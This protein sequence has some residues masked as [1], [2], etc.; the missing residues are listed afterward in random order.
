M[1]C[2]AGNVDSNQ[3]CALVSSPW[4]MVHISSQSL[5]RRHIAGWKLNIEGAHWLWD[6]QS[7]L[8]WKYRILLLHSRECERRNTCQNENQMCPYRMPPWEGQC[9]LDA[10]LIPGLG[11][12]VPH[13]TPVSSLRSLLPSGLIRK[14]HLQ[15]AERPAGVQHRSHNGS[16]GGTNVTKVR[17]PALEL[18]PCLWHSGAPWSL[19]IRNVPWGSLESDHVLFFPGLYIIW[20]VL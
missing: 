1:W 2:L 11:P 3:F 18:T 6:G 5:F 19:G 10:R 17:K 14:V 7:Y 13:P 15:V 9:D 20:K 16:D 12:S 4:M 8:L